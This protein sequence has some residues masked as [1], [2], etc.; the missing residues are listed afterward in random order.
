MGVRAKTT[1][2]AT[3]E[4]HF[5]DFELPLDID[6]KSYM[7]IVGTQAV[8][9]ISIKRSFKA[10]KYAM[11]AL[12]R[13][14]RVVTPEIKPAP[15]PTLLDIRDRWRNSTADPSSD[16]YAGV[17]VATIVNK[18]GEDL[19]AGTDL[20][21]QYLR[22]ALIEI[23]RDCAAKG[24]DSAKEGPDKDSR[25]IKHNLGELTASDKE[26]MSKKKEKK[27]SLGGLKSEKKLSGLESL[28]AK[29]EVKDE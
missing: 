21:R 29:L 14:L 19:A 27:P 3:L 11:V 4:K 20:E 18:H 16:P 24:M 23:W 13:R 17:N 28:R 26:H 6:Q 2:L 8:S 25:W 10:W 5:L 7:S 9:V 22:G 12:R 15:Q 1:V